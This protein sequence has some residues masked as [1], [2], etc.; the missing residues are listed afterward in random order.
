MALPKFLIRFIR[1]FIVFLIAGMF[2]LAYLEL[3]K[4]EALAYRQS[5]ANIRTAS[6]L[7]QAHLESTVSKFYILEQT[8]LEKGFREYQNIVRQI[9]LETPIY[10]DIVL[11]SES[12]DQ[13]RS[14]HGTSLTNSSAKTLTWRKL[15][16]YGD[17]FYV[18]SIYEKEPGHWV[19]AVKHSNP[20]LLFNVWIEFDLLYTTQHFKDLKTLEDG[21][22]FVVDASEK[23]LVF[24][25]DP[26]RVGTRSISYGAG[27]EDR[28]DS[29][30]RYGKIEYYYKGDNKIS[31]FDADNDLDWVFVSGT[32]RADILASSYQISLTAIVFSS[33]LFLTVAV[34]YITFQ[35]NQDLAKLNQASDLLQFKTQ[36]KN[37]FKRFFS[38]NGVQ[39][40]LYDSDT[41]A[42][43][44]IDYHGN[45]KV[46]LQSESLASR[47][48]NQTNLSYK[49]AKY[50]DEL[51]QSLKI[52][53]RHYTIPLI[54]QGELTGVI[55]LCCSLPTY[56]T[57]ILL[58]RDFTQVSLS[59]LMLNHKLK[60]KDG[61]TNLD[62][63]PQLYRHLSTTVDSPNRYLAF[64]DID[65]F[66]SINDTYGHQCG[67]HVIIE[68]ANTMRSLFSAPRGISVARYGGEEFCI[69]FDALTSQ[70]A[71]E[72]LEHLRDE[73]EN[74]DYRYND[75]ELKVTVSIGLTK[76]EQDQ[77]SSI[78]RADLALY[79]A[80]DAGKNQV[81]MKAA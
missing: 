7:I 14:Y 13:Y 78:E 37:I 1:P 57:L 80:K 12:K 70:E 30:V 69:L 71:F 49:T 44:S 36:M 81:I 77:H 3:Q 19:F 21:Y 27:I 4:T 76:A 26:K 29:G 25:P 68:V 35:L 51:A 16:D 65:N 23:R 55:Y 38:H 59:N 48:G 56:R 50:G 8:W 9:L 47:L 53:S 6:S 73:I 10:S 54:N 15:H 24:H 64:V 63:K 43:S 52:D 22:V 60:N 58:V 11:H 61:M 32:G 39:L 67:D 41:H 72:R 42:F 45:L 31:V 75:I 74:T 5:Q 17:E 33:L 62:N 20:K 66:K 18:S 34:N 28:V 40:C 46:M 2:Y 79:R